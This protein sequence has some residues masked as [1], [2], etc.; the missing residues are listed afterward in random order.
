MS[1]MKRACAGVLMAVLVCAALTAASANAALPRGTFEGPIDQPGYDYSAIITL[2]AGKL[3]KGVQA[4]TSSYPG[5]GCSGSLQ[6]RKKAKRGKYK[7]VEQITS[8]PE[9]TC[10]DVTNITLRRTTAG[11]LTYKATWSGGRATGT[12][13]KTG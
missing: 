9:Q 1:T 2:Q 11:G 10:V 7:F 3:V 12:L 8:D 4:G 5:L 13:V 6:F